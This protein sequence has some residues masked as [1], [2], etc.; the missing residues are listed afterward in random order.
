MHVLYGL[1]GGVWNVNIYP[2][3]G[4]KIRGNPW[5]KFV[6]ENDLEVGDKCIFELTDANMI[7]FKV[8]TFKGDHDSNGQPSQGRQEGTICICYNV[9]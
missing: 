1:N 5:G 9:D 2:R 7:S 8:S 4:H 3:Y 6:C